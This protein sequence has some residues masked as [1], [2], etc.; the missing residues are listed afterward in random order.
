MQPIFVGDVQGC[1]DEFSELLDRAR[2]SFGA[3][4]FTLW[5][6]GDLVNRGP[7]LALLRTVA[8]WSSAVARTSC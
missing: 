2:H 7:G 4:G 1:V 6:V 3:G 8:G 5:I